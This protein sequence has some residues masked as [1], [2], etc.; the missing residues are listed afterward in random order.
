M[1]CRR[2]GWTRQIRGDRKPKKVIF[3]ASN[4]IADK[5]NKVKVGKIDTM[6]VHLGSWGYL[7]G[8]EGCDGWAKAYERPIYRLS[9]MAAANGMVHARPDLNRDGRKPLTLQQML[10]HRAVPGTGWDGMKVERR[11]M[12]TA[13]LATN[14]E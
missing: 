11:E 14:E 1:Q 13:S 9:I 2:T 12:E 5:G 4:T 7:E 3:E 8:G 10:E 6:M